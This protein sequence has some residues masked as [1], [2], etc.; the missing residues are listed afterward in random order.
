MEA[1]T[2]SGGSSS[3]A[4][5]HCKIKRQNNSSKELGRA[6]EDGL[7]TESE[8]EKDLEIEKVIKGIEAMDT[9]QDF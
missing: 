8:D 5:R 6:V 3:G 2:S 4:G 7:L 9:S 1:G